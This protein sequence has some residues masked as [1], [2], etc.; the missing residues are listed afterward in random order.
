MSVRKVWGSCL[1]ACTCV[2]T[3][4]LVAFSR[5]SRD[6]DTMARDEYE[7]VWM[8]LAKVWQGHSRCGP[9]KFPHGSKMSAA[10][11]ID[12]LIRAR[13]LTSTPR[14]V[15]PRLCAE[16]VYMC[17][18]QV[19]F[20]INCGLQNQIGHR[21]R[22]KSASTVWFQSASSRAQLKHPPDLIG[23]GL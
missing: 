8:R 7:A 12:V 13:C 20:G 14:S 11:L 4:L 9:E 5:E 6:A 17:L 2:C 15:S 23:V 3:R 1:C 16:C 19:A 22:T 21:C 10:L 18:L